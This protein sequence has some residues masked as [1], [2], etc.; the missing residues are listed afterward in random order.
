[1]TPTVR[2]CS[3]FGERTVRFCVGKS[4]SASGLDGNPKQGAEARVWLGTRGLETHH[5]YF[6]VCEVSLAPQVPH[7]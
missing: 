4:E 5:C 6:L 2:T 3:N 7:P 1:M